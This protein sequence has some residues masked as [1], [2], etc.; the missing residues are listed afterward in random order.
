MARGRGV[1]RWHEQTLR[2]ILSLALAAAICAAA[3]ATHLQHADIAGSLV[4]RRE[5]HGGPGGGGPGPRGGPLGPGGGPDGDTNNPI[6]PYYYFPGNGAVVGSGYIPVASGN[7]ANNGGTAGGSAAAGPPN[8]ASAGSGGAS[9]PAP[10]QARSRSAV[11][12]SQA[13]P[14]SS[15]S[16]SCDVNSPN[17]CADNG[18]NSR[19]VPVTSNATLTTLAGMFFKTVPAGGGFIAT[20]VTPSGSLASSG[21]IRVNQT[22]AAAPQAFLNATINLNRPAAVQGP[23]YVFAAGSHICIPNFFSAQPA[24]GIP[25]ASQ[26]AAAAG[27]QPAISSGSPGGSTPVA[28]S[29]AA[30]DS[31]TP[32]AAAATRTTASA[33]TSVAAAGT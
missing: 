5:L 30:Q 17:C 27:A 28:A 29:G 12:P 14:V 24:P 7:T 16:T 15:G 8:Q 4:V 2:S 33:S 22:L 3:Q 11:S 18:L 26:S 21:Q 1:R 32:V 6:Y 23:D 13:P 31:A 25:A 9:A 19:L 10:A 20:P